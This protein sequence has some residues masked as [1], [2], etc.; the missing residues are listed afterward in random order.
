MGWALLGCVGALVFVISL[1]VYG[2]C[3]V[4]GRCSDKEGRDGLL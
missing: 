4:S 3:C 2:A 1:V